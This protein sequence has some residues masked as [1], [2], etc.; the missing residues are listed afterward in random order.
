ML[1]MRRQAKRGSKD[2]YSRQVQA[3]MQN[4]ATMTQRIQK[5]KYKY[6][7]SAGLQQKR[8]A[9]AAASTL[10][11]GRPGPGATLLGAGGHNIPSMGAW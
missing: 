10:K 1:A 8:R 3:Q 2:A 9:T 4:T 7:I 11:G 5:Q 6:P